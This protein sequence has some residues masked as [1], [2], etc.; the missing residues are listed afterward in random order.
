ALYTRR[1]PLGLLGNTINADEG[2]WVLRQSTAGAGMDSYF[3][4]LLKAY[5]LFGDQW[6][7][8]MFNNTYS[9]AMTHLR[10]RTRK[11]HKAWLVD[12]H[13]ETGT[14]ARPW[15]S[16]LQSFWPGMQS[17]VGHVDEA[18]E[19]YHD[20]EN[21]SRAM[22]FL[23]ELF[24][25]GGTKAHPTEKGYPLRPEL[26]ESMYFLYS[27]SHNQS[28]LQTGRHTQGMLQKYT[29]AACGYASMRD[30]AS[31]QLDDH[32]E[33][34]FL[35]ETMKYLYLLWTEALGEDLPL[36]PDGEYV[37][38]TEGHIFPLELDL[39]HNDQ[40]PPPP[41]SSPPRDDT[42]LQ[43][44]T[45]CK[46][47]TDRAPRRVQLGAPVSRVGG[48]ASDDRGTLRRRCCEACVMTGGAAP[49]L[50]AEP[51]PASGQQ[52]EEGTCAA[53]EGEEVFDAAS[54]SL[55]L[56]ELLG[57]DTGR[58]V[59]CRAAN[60]AEMEGPWVNGRPLQSSTPVDFMLR[61]TSEMS[62]LYAELNL[63][64]GRGRGVAA[65]GEGEAVGEDTDP[66]VRAVLASFGP[67]MVANSE[68]HGPLVAALPRN[69]CHV[70]EADR[71]PGD[72]PPEFRDA[73]FGS[74]LLVERGGCS[75]ISK[76]LYGQELG[77]AMVVVF[78]NE[79][80]DAVMMGE[81]GTGRNTNI[82]SVF[83]RRD[84]GL[85]LLTALAESNVPPE[86]MLPDVSILP[87][88]SMIGEELDLDSPPGLRVDI[89][90]GDASAPCKNKGINVTKEVG[91][92]GGWHNC[93]VVH[94]AMLIYR[95][96]R[97]GA[98]EA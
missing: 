63:N 77:A 51:A 67:P 76:V 19:M 8:H 59:R 30:V 79:K 50:I 24:D 88:V 49:Q 14:L 98:H 4:Y 91:Q 23:P 36:V 1:G 87:D 12:V 43:C 15:V 25:L 69:G 46:P 71:A 39:P 97:A 29:R 65:N 55:L 84:S 32:M 5:L 41:F 57:G 73:A 74:V 38:N 81:D 21:A 44:L 82:P 40:Q 27:H 61:L 18:V 54:Q 86:Q 89:K 62:N 56:C 26:I 35:A 70:D 17:L 16:S 2:N 94:E 80:G 58:S 42:P 6:H 34:F 64:R 37:F 48:A 96:K 11:Q 92:N 72:I 10:G 13:M 31:R 95:G 78:D 33:S 85:A 52:T 75:F 90:P 45:L 60:D 20:L 93:L 68:W 3:E 53:P 9:A 66:T 7:L 83:I 28:Y 22:G 47:D